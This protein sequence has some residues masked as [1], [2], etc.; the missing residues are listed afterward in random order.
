M[1]LTAKINKEIEAWEEKIELKKAQV[2][3][4][5][6]EIK[7]LRHLLGMAQKVEGNER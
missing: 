4:M 5:E 7:A 1:S 3:R 6:L 2:K